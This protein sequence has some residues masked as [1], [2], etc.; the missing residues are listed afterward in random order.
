[1]W[2]GTDKHMDIAT[3][4]LWKGSYKSTNNLWYQV[5]NI[6]RKTMEFFCFFKILNISHF[7]LVLVMLLLSSTM[8]SRNLNVGFL[9]G[10]LVQ[11]SCFPQE[12]ML[13]LCKKI[14]FVQ[15]QMQSWQ[16]FM[17][18]QDNKSAD[19]KCLHFLDPFT[20]GWLMFMKACLSS[21]M[22]TL[23]TYDFH[24]LVFFFTHT[25]TIKYR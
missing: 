15:A 9:V 11:F 24:P 23:I 5:F 14:F 8:Y 3:F 22:F 10:S 17:Q 6:N 4:T 2:R 13:K 25:F 19:K 1:M 20:K 18:F 7:L 12:N 16:T 21:N